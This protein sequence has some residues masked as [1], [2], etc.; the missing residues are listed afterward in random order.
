MYPYKKH[1]VLLNAPDVS[2]CFHVPY[3]ENKQFYKT[4]LL[5]DIY[6]KVITLHPIKPILLDTQLSPFSSK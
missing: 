1:F 3:I 5:L 2:I 6:L 4:L